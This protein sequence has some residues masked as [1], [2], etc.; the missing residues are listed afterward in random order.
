VVDAVVAADVASVVPG[1]GEPLEHAP[2]TRA[3]SRSAADSDGAR[4]LFMERLLSREG[5]RAPR[6]PR[7]VS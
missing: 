4:Y 1:S 7:Q 5:T 2:A 6:L 3:A